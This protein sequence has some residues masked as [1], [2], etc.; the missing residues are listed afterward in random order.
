MW[1]FE[2]ASLD[3]AAVSFST[4]DDLLPDEMQQKCPAEFG[5]VLRNLGDSPLLLP[6]SSFYPAQTILG[7]ATVTRLCS[8]FD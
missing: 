7:P 3:A 8:K 1:E 5:W 2:E 6:P 4:V